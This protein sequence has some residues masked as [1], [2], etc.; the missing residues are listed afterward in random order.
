MHSRAIVQL[1]VVTWMCSSGR[2]TM[3]VLTWLLTSSGQLSNLLDWLERPVETT[4]SCNTVFVG[5]WC[6]PLSSFSP[7]C[8]LLIFAPRQ[9]LRFSEGN[10]RQSFLSRTDSARVQTRASEET[11]AIPKAE[12]RPKTR[13]TKQSSEE[14]AP[15]SRSTRVAERR[16]MA[17][18]SPTSRACTSGIDERDASEDENAQRLLEKL[19]PEVWEKILD[20]LEEDDLFLLALSCSSFVRSRRSWWRGRGRTGSLAVL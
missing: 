8:S 7:L 18:G 6:S 11:V 2:S 17:K 15:T 19:P 3:A 12:S 4:S 20:D 9:V 1:R 16:K 14:R 13:G 5:A 10:A